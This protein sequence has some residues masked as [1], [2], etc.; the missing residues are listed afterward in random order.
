MKTIFKMFLFAA[1]L[2]LFGCASVSRD[3]HY[4]KIAKEH[5]FEYFFPSSGFAREFSTIEEAYEFVYAA[6][7]KF[8]QAVSNKRREKGLDAKLLVPFWSSI[9]DDTP[10]TLLGKIRAS[11]KHG[12]IDLSTT[13]KNIVDVLR[14]AEEALLFFCVFYNGRG[15]SLS[16]F[17]LDPKYSGYSDGNTQIQGIVIG[18]STIEAEYPV[19]WGIEKVFEYLRG[20]RD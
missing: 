12:E 16:N 4:A 7:K 9:L 6:D 19:G 3:I 20:E 15:A 17:Y 2:G 14:R 10:V 18:D 8:L 5:P 11:D 13:D 1:A